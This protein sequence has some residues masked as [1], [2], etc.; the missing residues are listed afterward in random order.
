MTF[1]LTRPQLRTLLEAS[2]PQGA[3]LS[4]H[5]STTVRSLLD[6]GYVTQSWRSPIHGRERNVRVPILL[7]TALGRQ[8]VEYT[9]KPHT[10]TDTETRPQ[11]KAR[12]R[13]VRPLI[14]QAIRRWESSGRL[15][16]CDVEGLRGWLNGGRL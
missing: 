8:A 5:A 12:L 11:M 1:R 9:G 15:E 7:I 10:R 6:A 4:A 2:T 13:A 3:S 14:E 16:L